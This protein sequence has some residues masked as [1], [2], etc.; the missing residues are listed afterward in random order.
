MKQ[1]LL[2]GSHSALAYLAHLLEYTDVAAAMEDP[3]LR[4]FIRNH[5]MENVTPTLLPVEGIDLANYKDTL[6]NRFSNRNIGDT[7]LRLAED[8]SRKI[9]IFMLRPLVKAIH[10]GKPHKALVLAL[11]GWARFLGGDDERGRPI[12]IKD[13]DGGPV[14]AAA[15]KAREN[16]T[17]FL[18]EAGVQGLSEN[19]LAKLA[20]AFKGCLEQLWQEGARKTLTAFLR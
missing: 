16:P 6:V 1:G 19:E 5:Y 7:I 20:E 18:R 9:P 2:N 11:A 14:I 15:K 8:G 13:P 10:A 3:D 17:A 12:P 4:S